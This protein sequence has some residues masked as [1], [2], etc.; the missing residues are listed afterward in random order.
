[1]LS[2][3]KSITCAIEQAEL[4]CRTFILTENV[5]QLPNSPHVSGNQQILL[6]QQINIFFFSLAV[7]LCGRNKHSPLFYHAC[8]HEKMHNKCI[9]KENKCCNSATIFNMIASCVC[10]S[11]LPLIYKDS[12]Q[13]ACRTLPPEDR[14]GITT[15]SEC[16]NC[17]SHRGWTK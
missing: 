2:C 9:S 5:A 16:Q 15:R 13:R 14:V 17:T 11:I 7:T 3:K 12:V 8:S 4:R 6:I 1:M 10:S